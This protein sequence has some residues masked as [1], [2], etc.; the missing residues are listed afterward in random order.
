MENHGEMMST[1]QNPDS[2][3][4]VILSVGSLLTMTSR[5]FNSTRDVMVSSCDFNGLKTKNI[6]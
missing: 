5:L 2:N 6:I 1:E 3:F 4:S